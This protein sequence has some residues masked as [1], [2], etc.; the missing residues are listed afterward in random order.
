MS[1]QESDDIDGVD[2]STGVRAASPADIDASGDDH[3]LG[4]DAA[5]L[6]GDFQVIVRDY[7]ED[8]YADWRATV[9]EYIANAE[10]ACHRTMDRANSDEQDVIVSDDYQPVIE[11]EWNAREQKLTVADNGIG[12]SSH[13]F[14][15]AFSHVG[16]TAS[17]HEGGRS[18]EFGVGSL[19]FVQ[20]SGIDEEMLIKTHSRLTD[21]NFAAYFKL[22]GT[23]PLVGGLD[24]DRYGTVFEIPAK[25]T[26]DVRSAVEEYAEW[27]SV[28]LRFTE[29][30]ESGEEVF[31]EDYGGKTLEDVI[32]PDNNRVVVE[33]EGYYKAVSSPDNESRTLLISMPIDRNTDVSSNGI[34]DNFDIRL[35][36]E[37]GRIVDGPN[38]GLIPC[39]RREYEEMLLNERDGY[40][41]LELCDSHDAVLVN[42]TEQSITDVSDEQ[43]YGE[44]ITSG[45]N[46]G[47]TIITESDW[48]ELPE[49]R[50]SEYIPEDELSDEDIAL[51]TPT[52]SRDQLERNE[53]F[54]EY[55]IE[56]LE[57]SFMVKVRTIRDRLEQADDPVEEASKIDLDEL[58]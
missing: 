9:R 55:V 56:N 35:Y 45:K 5:E 3:P 48:N 53:D 47:K 43:C 25:D 28:P 27:V 42:E 10:T 32:S 50:A 7:A 39:T 26:F 54:W 2:I 34:L 36:D 19:S 14:Q 16:A 18:G 11:I 22:G 57:D 30:D 31:N 15:H 46:K 13:E 8:Q 49:G 21:E 17:K 6:T 29:Y 12:M 33:E 58:F 37:S 24:D 52:S 38:K 41:T 51:P 20:I 4:S 44:E 1:Q 40:I 23:T